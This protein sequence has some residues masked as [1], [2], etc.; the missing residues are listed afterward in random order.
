MITLKAPVIVFFFYLFSILGS[1][2]DACS[3]LLVISWQEVVVDLREE[4]FEHADIKPHR[5][6]WILLDVK[7]KHFTVS[8]EFRQKEQIISVQE[9]C[10]T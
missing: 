1:A 2:A 9:A 8:V 3:G 7:I 5:F 10:L 6:V 4:R